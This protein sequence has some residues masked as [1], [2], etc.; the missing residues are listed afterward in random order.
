MRTHDDNSIYE[1]GKQASSLVSGK[2]REQLHTFI[3]PLLQQLDEQIDRRLVNSFDATLQ[4]ILQ[5]RNRACGLLLSELGSYIL[6]PD[7]APAGTK[8]LSNLLRSPKWHYSLIEDFLWGKA[9][10]RVEELESQ[11]EEVLV[12]GA[13]QISFSTGAFLIVII[14]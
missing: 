8:R 3:A 4:A 1:E 2:L 13:L 10:S 5:L 9:H 7:K 6:T 14:S 12:A 11:G